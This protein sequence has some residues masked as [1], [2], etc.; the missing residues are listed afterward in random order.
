MEKYELGKRLGKGYSS[1][2][3]ICRTKD[4]KEVYAMKILW[5]KCFF[6]RE[7][8]MLSKIKHKNVIDL[9]EYLPSNEDVKP[10]IVILPYYK[11]TLDPEI[12]PDT[13]LNKVIK[14]ILEGIVYL[15]SQNVIHNDIKPDNILLDDDHSP[16]ICDF[17][18]SSFF[19]EGEKKIDY[20]YGT[21]IF[22]C[23][24]KKN[25]IPYT[26]KT[27][28]WSYGITVVCCI[29]KYYEVNEAMIQRTIS[30]HPFVQACLTQE[31]ENRPSSAALLLTF[32]KIGDSIKS[33]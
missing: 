29:E 27:D 33:L 2:V 18:L 9:I 22:F 19:S 14:G 7:V 5:K 1:T 3:V 26:E 8:E 16:I 20:N 21:Y 32:D 28:V 6:E 25:K 13:S 31:E 24:N 30:K 4:T 15:H 17:G 12:L 10:Y 23:P 11:N